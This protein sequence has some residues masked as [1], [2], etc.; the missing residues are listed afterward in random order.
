M[1]RNFSPV[2]VQRK[3]LKGVRQ[4]CSD[5]ACDACAQMQHDLGIINVTTTG[6]VEG[7]GKRTRR[8]YYRS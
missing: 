7:E 2:P 5:Y 8:L 4:A 6:A 1:K 3:A